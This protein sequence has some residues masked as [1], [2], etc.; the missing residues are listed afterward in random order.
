MK[1]R[2]LW[3]GIILIAIALAAVAF[4]KAGAF[5]EVSK[6]ITMIFGMYVIGNVGEH[7][8]KKK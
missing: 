6:F 8:S 3:G 4:G 1:S 2:K 7:L 5:M